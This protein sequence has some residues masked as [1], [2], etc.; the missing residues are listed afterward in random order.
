MLNKAN[1]FNVFHSFE[2]GNWLITAFELHSIEKTGW[3]NMNYMER[4]A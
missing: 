1:S 2:Y 3:Q 4:M